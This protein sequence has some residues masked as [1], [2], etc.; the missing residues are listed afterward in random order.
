MRVAF[1]IVSVWS[2]LLTLACLASAEEP[3]GVIERAIAAEGGRHKLAEIG[4][5]TMKWQGTLY[6]P[7]PQPFMHPNQQPF[8]AEVMRQWPDR[9]KNVYHLKLPNGLYTMMAVVNGVDAWMQTDDGLNREPERI[10]SYTRQ[11]LQTAVYVDGTVSRL[12][13]LV[14]ET[15][16]AL[17]ALPATKVLNR[18][19]TG[20]NV[21][22]K[23]HPDVKLYFD[24]E[25]GLLVKKEYRTVKEVE[26]HGGEVLISFVY[27]QY[28]TADPA[29]ADEDTLKAAHVGADDASL[30]AYLREHTL[31]NVDEEDIGTLIRHL[32]DRSF[33]V[34][35]KATASLIARGRP[36][37]P[38]LREALKS[39]DSETKDR[40]GRCIKQIESTKVDNV[41]V[42]VL[43][44]IS[45]RKPAGAALE[46]LAY[47]PSAP[48]ANVAAAAR[49]ALAAVAVHDGKPDQFLKEVAHD[50]SPARRAAAVAILEHKRPGAEVRQLLVSGIKY[51]ARVTE[52]DNGKKIAQFEVT[53]IRFFTALDPGTFKRP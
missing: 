7:A 51:P 45:L 41:A 32:G 17:S 46:I 3:K 26:D 6:Q 29:A 11:E 23:G 18:P 12:L 39:T 14:D 36:A 37:L 21:R 20:V 42:A 10:S 4:A 2:L 40:A 49:E 35:E 24:N 50:K 1:C 13:P 47:L 27:E 48:D 22:A 25:T 53:E 19:A 30:L 34:R 16:F 38:A 5:V 52:Y 33:A 31:G 9:V 44:L 15:R 28:R 8:T 43:H